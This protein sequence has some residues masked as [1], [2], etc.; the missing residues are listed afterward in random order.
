[1][2]SKRIGKQSIQFFKPPHIIAAA[3]VVGKKEGEGPLHTYFDYID[4]TDLFGG[5][6]WEDAESS[7]QRQ[8]VEL[9]I[10]KA[11]YQK[12]EIHYILAGDLLGQLIASSFGIAKLS[13]PFLGIYGACST[14]GEGLIMASM[15]IDGGFAEK[16]VNVT[17][18][19]FASAEKEFRFPL[20]YGNQRPLAATWT[21]TGSGAVVLA[22]EEEAKKKKKQNGNKPNI[23]ITG[24]TVGKIID[25]G[26]KDKSNMG[27]CM[28]P[29]AC[30]TVASH[31]RDFGRKPEYYDKII[32]GDLGA[33]GSEIFLQLLQEEGFDAQAV[34]EDC[35]M[36]IYDN[37]LQD[38]HSG[39]SGCGCSAVTFTAYLLNELLE[40]RW[41][42]ILFVPTGAL[43]S[44]VSTNEGR[45]IPGVAHAV[46]VEWQ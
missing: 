33:I 16:T 29:A 43:L 28:A 44:P 24:A 13:I 27:A 23:V 37:E 8:V 5:E 10:Q 14:M 41:K 9:A 32:T 21:V 3:S 36:L 38:T 12:E 4:E 34:H 22:N 45:T 46:V 20:G 7:M 15:L 39:G 19:H 25:Y 42:R 40:K 2:E 31:L 26:V 18:S 17:S 6:N 30:Q 1:M 11:E 35:G